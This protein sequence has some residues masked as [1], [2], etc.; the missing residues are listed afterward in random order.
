MYSSYLVW[1]TMKCMEKTLIIINGPTC[2]G[3]SAVITE[4]GKL[5]NGFFHLSYDRVKWCFLDYK[6]GSHASEVYKMLTALMRECVEAGVSVIKDGGLYKEKIIPL[7]EMATKAGYK[8]VEVNLEAPKEELL[9]RFRA[10]VEMNTNPLYFGQKSANISEDRF[11]E[12]NEMYESS[13]NKELKTYDTSLMSSEEI[14][15]DILSLV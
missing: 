2:V 13:K 4:L 5:R 8:I 9:K 1:S 7:A 11:W 12:L 15:K 3:K 14:A 10:R 6:S